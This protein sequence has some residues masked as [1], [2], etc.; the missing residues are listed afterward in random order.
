MKIKFYDFQI[1]GETFSVWDDDSPKTLLKMLRR[2]L[3]II[4]IDEFAAR[5][6]HEVSRKLLVPEGFLDKNFAAVSQGLI[7]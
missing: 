4:S 3:M 6:E 5:L 7:S 2:R 1:S